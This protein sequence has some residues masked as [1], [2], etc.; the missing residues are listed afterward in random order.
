MLWRGT[1]KCTDGE[2]GKEG[3]SMTRKKKGNIEKEI[4]RDSSVAANA[5]AISTQHQ[6]NHVVRAAEE[7]CRAK[8]ML[9]KSI[10]WSKAMEVFSM[11]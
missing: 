8:E 5:V 10:T 6:S 7:F 1:G 3:S 9:K 11:C 2:V 4:I